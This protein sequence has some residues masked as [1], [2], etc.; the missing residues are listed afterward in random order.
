MLAVFLLVNAYT[1][2]TMQSVWKQHLGILSH[3]TSFDAHLALAHDLWQKGDWTQTKNELLIAQTLSPSSLLPEETK[4]V[5]GATAS[6]VDLLREWE[7]EPKRLE[8]E[9][10]FWQTVV[11]QKPDYRDG[12]IQ[13]AAISYQLGK[14]DG[15]KQ[16]LATAQTLDPNSPAVQQLLALFA[17]EQ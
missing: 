6:P 10:Q 9:F 14:V 3:P 16:Y 11:A 5:L 15:A 13:L 12:F 7:E 17:K 8:K 4:K 1:R 2:F